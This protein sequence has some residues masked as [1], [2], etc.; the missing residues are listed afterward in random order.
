MI[1]CRVRSSHKSLRYFVHGAVVGPPTAAA[2][3]SKFLR[4]SP[5]R[6]EDSL[7]T[8]CTQA[9]GLMSAQYESMAKRMQ[10]GFAARNGLF[11]ALMSREDYTGIDQVFE[12]PYGG[13]LSIFG[14]GSRNDPPYIK[15]E[16]VDGLGEN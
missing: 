16:L 8:A 4:L 13:F 5:R 7:N 6:I 1:L 10:H 2:A 12:R 3:V 9:C 11:A 15:N 14:Q